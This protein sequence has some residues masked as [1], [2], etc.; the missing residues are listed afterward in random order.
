[1]LLLGVNNDTFR[2]A[3]EALSYTSYLVPPNSQFSA[4]PSFSFQPLVQLPCRNLLRIS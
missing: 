4:I 2:N 1:M 3:K